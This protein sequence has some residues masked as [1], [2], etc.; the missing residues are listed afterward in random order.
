MCGG[1]L[2]D[3]EIAPGTREAFGYSLD[4][5]DSHESF[6]AQRGRVGKKTNY[7][8]NHLL[9]FRYEEPKR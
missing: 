4:A 6:G 5:V 7:N 8:V 1:D 2:G 9:N 3:S